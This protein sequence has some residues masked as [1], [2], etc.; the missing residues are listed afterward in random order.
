[1]TDAIRAFEGLT[2]A[3]LRY[4]DS[5]FD[6]RFDEL[7]AERQRISTGTASCIANR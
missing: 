4:F 5:A 3:Y 6:L 2:E 7:V 1:M